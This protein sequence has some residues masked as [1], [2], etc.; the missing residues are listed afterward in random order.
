[1]NGWIVPR[2][3]P[4]DLSVVVCTYQRPGHLRRCLLS[5]AVQRNLPEGFEV[6]VTDDGSQ[7]ETADVAA[8]FARTVDF[9]VAWT[10]HAHDGFQASR[11]RND[12][13]R[14]A[15]GSYLLF[16]DG[17]CIVPHDHLAQH[18][19]FRR[20]GLVA[21]GDCCRLDEAHSRFV[22]D[23]AVLSGEY[24]QWTPPTERKR[25]HKRH[26]HAWFY[27]AIR[28]GRKPSLIGNDVGVWYADYVRVNGYDENYRGWGCEDDDFGQ[29]LRWAGLRL[30][31]IL[32]RTWAYHLWHATD[33]SAPQRWRDGA[34]VKYFLSRP[35]VAWC[36]NGLSKRL[37]AQAA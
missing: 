35:R 9:P 8:E 12:G 17:D 14:L 32:G 22:T 5:L 15:R 20:P 25:L 21:L 4:R 28:H 3:K 13:V 31:S 16:L 37:A 6:V 1:M 11:T 7:D 18:L 24:Q 2:H 30:H 10:T 27:S 19:L 23:A 29:R 33:P 36:E 26:R 34:N